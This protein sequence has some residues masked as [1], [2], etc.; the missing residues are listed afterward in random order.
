[1]NIKTACILA[2]FFITSIG[3]MA[4]DI[5]NGGFENW[6]FYRGTNFESPA[7]W[8]TNDI[9]TYKI[10]PK[11]KGMSTSKSSEAHTGN[12][13]VKMQVV[14]DHGDTANG[15]IYSTTSVDSIILLDEGKANAGFRY[16]LHATS[17]NGNYKFTSAAGSSDSA[18]FGITLTKW[19]KEKH[20]RDILVNTIFLIGQNSR[21]YLPFVIPFRYQVQQENPDTALVVIGIQGPHG[22]PA[23]EGT[24]LFIDDIGFAAKMPI[25]K[26]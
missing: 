12:Y 2:L 17:L 18:F 20:R 9:L 22:K 23:H 8:T 16:F 21:D 13:A 25:K 11:Y 24:T 26:D 1:M 6:N 14:V 3:A 19:N 4:Q 10:N 7:G 5:P 15:C